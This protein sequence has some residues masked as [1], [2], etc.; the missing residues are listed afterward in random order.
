MSIGPKRDDILGIFATDEDRNQLKEAILE[1]TREE[2]QRTLFELLTKHS[3]SGSKEAA[4]LSS[5]HQQTDHPPAANRRRSTT[6][7]RRTNQTHR[8]SSSAVLLESSPLFQPPPQSKAQRAVR[9]PLEIDV[10][11]S[12]K[13]QRSTSV[14]LEKSADIFIKATGRRPTKYSSFDDETDTKDKPV[15]LSLNA[16]NETNDDEKGLQRVE[17]W[18][19]PSRSKSLVSFRPSET[20]R[21]IRTSPHSV[22]QPN[23]P[24]PSSTALERRSNWTSTVASERNRALELDRKLLGPIILESKRPNYSMVLPSSL[25]VDEW[26][27]ELARNIINVFSNKVRSDIKQCDDVDEYVPP[28]TAASKKRMN[29]V[30][31]FFQDNEIDERSDLE[32]DFQRISISRGQPNNCFDDCDNT[33]LDRPETA[34]PF[35]VSHARQSRRKGRL[36][37]GGPLRLRMIWLTS[38]SRVTDWQV[39]GG[40]VLWFFS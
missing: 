28:P 31:A 40:K 13:I 36:S 37:K 23:A 2:V 20:T 21:L 35:K 7:A 14:I 15:S 11:K 6:T 12:N 5:S 26:E 33:F 32:S 4:G 18:P 30:G 24:R 39:L 22:T 29:S 1:C 3:C 38:T 9:V 17:S 16:K 19:V 34:L 25:Q 8:A 27:N 10:P